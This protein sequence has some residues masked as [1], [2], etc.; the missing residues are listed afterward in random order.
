MDF[1]SEEMRKHLPLAE[2]GDAPAEF[3]ISAPADIVRLRLAR[4]KAES[5]RFYLQ[6]PRV[7]VGKYELHALAP[8]FTSSSS[9]AGTGD[10]PAGRPG[11][12]SCSGP[13]ERKDACC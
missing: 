10:R 3:Y 4:C 13:S 12:I 1:L 11:A 5:A 6:D 2:T 7:I 8:R 9:M